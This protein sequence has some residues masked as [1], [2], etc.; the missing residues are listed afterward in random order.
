MK[1]G[2]T[3]ATGHLG[4]LVVEK[5]KERVDPKIIVA[6]VRTPEKVSDNAIEARRF[7]YDEPDNL[8]KS[9]EGIDHLLLISGSEV[10]K[11]RQQHENVIKAAKQAGVKWIVYTSLLHADKST[12]SLA[13]EH[14]A[15]EAALKASGIAHTILR[16]GWYTENYTASITASVK[17]GA[18]IGCAGEGKISSAARDDYAEA[19]VVVLTSVN[20]QGKVYELAGDKHYTLTE[21]AAEVS[22][23]TGIKI[24]YKNLTEQEYAATLTSFG[25]P[26]ELAK[27]IAGYDAAASRNDLFDD[28]KQL[29]QLIGRSTTTLAQSIKEALI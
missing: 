6:L 22:R 17:N 9:L 25:M 1:I 14:R 19:A 2:I 15:T 28:S 12:I 11:R 26:D 3:G 8:S 16:N 13:D 21:L 20:Q 24:H 4:R 27:A 10:G 23:Q 29:S 5:L 7:N 18:F